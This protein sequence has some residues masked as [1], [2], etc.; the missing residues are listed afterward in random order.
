MSNAPGPAGPSKTSLTA[1]GLSDPSSLAAVSILVFTFLVFWWSPVTQVTDSNY[2]MLLSQD[3]LEHRSFMLDHYAIPRLTPEFHYN[4]IM[5]GEIHQLELRDGH[6]Y[7]Y[8]PPGTSVLSVP[9]VALMKA[10]G[11]SAANPDGTHNLDA[12]KSVCR[13]RW[14]HF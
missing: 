5:N 8:F 12:E 9:F 7:Y 11:V 1:R 4:T 13:R 14:R 3:L 2:A 6:L 10:N